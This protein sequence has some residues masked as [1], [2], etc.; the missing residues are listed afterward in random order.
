MQALKETLSSQ[1]KQLTEL[2]A[3]YD[4]SVA[5]AEMRARGAI[6][7]VTQLSNQVRGLKAML[8]EREAERVKLEADKIKMARE[9][10]AREATLKDQ[11]VAEAAAR[12]ALMKES[13][14]NEMRAMQKSEQL[15]RQASGRMTS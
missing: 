6:D 7:E 13:Q 1:S 4:G 15:L 5:S 11:L 14:V 12:A 8:E 10:E 3:A 2:R 9:Q